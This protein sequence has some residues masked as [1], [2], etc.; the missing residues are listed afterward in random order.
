MNLIESL[1]SLIVFLFDQ[2][3]AILAAAVSLIQQLPQMIEFLTDLPLYVPS[4]CVA[5]LGAGIFGTIILIYLGRR[6]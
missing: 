2:L 3:K 5:F 6:S 4:F 1:F